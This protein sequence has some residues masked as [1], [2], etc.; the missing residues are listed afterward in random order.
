MRKPEE[1]KQ[2][3]QYIAETN[4]TRKVDLIR[5]GIAYRF[6]EDLAADTIAYIQQLEHLFRYATKNV[7]ELEAAQKWISVEERLPDVGVKVLTLDRHGHVQDRALYV[8]LDGTLAFRPDGMI[9]KKHVTHWMPFPE[10]PE[11]DAN[12]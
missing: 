5:A 12:E 11:V 10:P 7:D 1:I 6:T 9:P 3:L 4:V 8:F 2:E